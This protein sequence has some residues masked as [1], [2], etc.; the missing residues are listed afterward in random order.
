MTLTRQQSQTIVRTMA[1]VMN[2]LDRSWLELKGKCSDADFAEYGRKVSAALE[3]LSCEVLVPI[4]QEHPE[5][6]PL[7]DEELANL[8]QDQ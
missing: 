8:G 4:F 5:L 1:Q 3:N 2:D 6:E 7:A